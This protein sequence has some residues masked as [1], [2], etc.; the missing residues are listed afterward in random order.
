M[1]KDFMKA[2]GVRLWYNKNCYPKVGEVMDEFIQATSDWFGN[3][4]TWA[5]HQPWLL[6]ILGAGFVV[7]VIIALVSDS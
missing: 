7:M 2:F 3:M 6:S 1:K 5:I 4:F